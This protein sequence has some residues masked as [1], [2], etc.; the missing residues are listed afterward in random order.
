MTTTTPFDRVVVVGLGLIGG[1]LAQVLAPHVHVVGVDIDAATR[2]VAFADGIEVFD[3]VGPAVAANALVVVAVP[4]TEMAAVFDELGGYGDIVVTDVASVKQ[5]VV[6]L[7][8]RAKLQFVGGHP[9]AGREV[10]GYGAASDSLFSGARWALCI[11]PATALADVFAVA[12]VVLATG[13]AV[14]PTLAVDHDRAVAGVSHL[15]HVV[16]AALAGR[17]ADDRARELLLALAA[18]SFRDAT[19]VAR[20]PAKFWAGIVG[21]N[22]SNLTGVVRDFAAE[23]AAVADAIERQDRETVEAFF[24]RGVRGRVELEQRTA[25]A[26]TF[27]IATADLER[28]STASDLVALGLRGG[29]IT[30][31]ERTA[32]GFVVHAR[33]PERPS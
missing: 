16:A 12:E 4:V 26:T 29:A 24:D 14:V 27:E 7:A 10:A 5:P 19:R 28:T 22:A 23:L 20:S 6:D 1:S 33:V 31:L 32:S 18:G 21:E 15:P 30:R 8:R 3:E 25:V 17:S 2:A 9:M 13:A 11:E